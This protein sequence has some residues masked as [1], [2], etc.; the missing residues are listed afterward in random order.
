VPFAVVVPASA[1]STLT[2]T[3]VFASAVPEIVGV[4]SLM[5]EPFAGSRM[6]GAVGGVASTVN[7]STLPV[8]PVLPAK[9]VA[10]AVTVCEPS[11]RGVVGV[12][13][14]FDPT[15]L[16]VATD[17]PSTI[18]SMLVFTS[19]VPEY[20]GVLSLVD[21][22]LAGVITVAAAGGVLSTVKLFVLLST[23]LTAWL[24]LTA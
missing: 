17:D 8:A 12:K 23:L 15:A 3:E 2:R 6:L 18:T 11:V 14:Q 24:V 16:T 1:P 19:L 4:L 22:P 13:L 7:V 9:S 21:E 10:R 5:L 20:V